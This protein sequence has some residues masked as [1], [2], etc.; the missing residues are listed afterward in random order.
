MRGYPLHRVLG[1]GSLLIGLG[2]VRG[3]L[4][5]LGRY[6]GLVAGHGRVRG[7]LYR[8]GG[9]EVLPVL[10][11]EEGYNFRRSRALVT[12]EDGGT[13]RA[14]VYR[15]RGGRERA[16]RIPDGDYRRAHPRSAWR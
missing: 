2:H 16:V 13:S 3:V 9:P 4:L 12:L 14:W 11:R 6:P 1:S 7:E 8:L 5:D 15:Y 10:D